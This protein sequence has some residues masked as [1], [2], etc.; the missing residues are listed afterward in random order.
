MNPIWSKCIPQIYAQLELGVNLPWVYVHA[1]LHVPYVVLWYSR[2]LCLI[3]VG[4]Q[5]AMGICACCSICNL[6]G[7]IVFQRSMLDWMG[8]QYA[9]GICAC[10]LY[11][12]YLV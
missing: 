3:G 8:C 11:E 9:M 12:T 7:V 1:A 5:S 6:S 2:E 10:C 4:C